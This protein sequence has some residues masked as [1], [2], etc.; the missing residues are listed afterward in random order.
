MATPTVADNAKEARMF[1]KGMALYAPEDEGSA[2]G[3]ASGGED[4]GSGKP[5][6]GEKAIS[7]SQ[8]RAILHS[9]DE[10]HQREMQALRTEMEQKLTA[11]AEKPVHVDQPKR[12][13]RAELNAA[14]EAKQI[15]QDQADA[16]WDFQ[17]REDTKADARKVATE[18]VTA[19]QRKQRV[20]TE[21]NRY[22]AAAPEILDE[23][24]ET[25]QRIRDEFQAL[26]EL[27]DD[28][29]DVTTQLKAIR[30]VLGPVDKLERARN[31]KPAHESHREFGGGGGEDRSGKKKDGVLTYDDLSS[32]EK[33]H[34]DKGIASGLYKDK[35]AVN[36]ELAFAKPHI[37]QKYGARV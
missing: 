8:L 16:Q 24:H 26:I 32:R 3:G 4:Q 19:E 14:V 31:G 6:D 17:V 28:S 37:R 21:I 23:G 7:Q 27:G 34:Y 22:K 29:K 20:D 12:Y 11:V 35:E 30:A 9:A 33:A 18:T 25:R 2:G 36:A 1:K 5:K 13:T 15:T 10:K